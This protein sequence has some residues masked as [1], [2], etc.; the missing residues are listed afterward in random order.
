MAA[1]LC[2]ASGCS[3]AVGAATHTGRAHLYLHLDNGDYDLGPLV[4]G[5]DLST[6]ERKAY[7]GFDLGSASAPDSPATA[8]TVNS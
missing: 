4:K 8:S 1:V 3:A 2:L 5:I 6:D 7:Y